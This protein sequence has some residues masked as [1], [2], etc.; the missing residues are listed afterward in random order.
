MEKLFMQ[1]FS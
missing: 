1:A